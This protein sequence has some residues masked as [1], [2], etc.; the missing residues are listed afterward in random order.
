MHLCSSDYWQLVSWLPF[1]REKGKSPCDIFGGQ[2]GARS[3]KSIN[4]Q[5]LQN[6]HKLQNCQNLQNYH[7]LQNCQNLQKCQNPSHAF[8]SQAQA[9]LI[10]HHTN[11]T[12]GK[13]FVQP[14][15][16]ASQR[17][18]SV[19]HSARGSS[20]FREGQEASP[21]FCY[22][23]QST[24]GPGALANLLQ[25]S[26]VSQGTGSLHLP[27]SQPRGLFCGQECSVLCLR[28]A[29][30]FVQG[31]LCVV[32]R[33]AQCPGR[34]PI[35]RGR[36]S[37]SGL[38]RPVQDWPGHPRCSPV[39]PGLFQGQAGPGGPRTVPAT[40]GSEEDQEAFSC[41]PGNCEVG[42]RALSP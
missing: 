14:W 18:G 8:S 1:N 4:H 5:K 16:G 7:K 25:L 2:C 20:Q 3:I 38:S 17:L 15:P 21:G 34:V 24:Q 29:L 35:F 32:F 40:P 39:F 6:Y 36:S 10:H 12:F 28:S 9:S 23:L 19:V 26:S 41:C 42:P 13:G 27:I 11:S 30:C 33:S 37:V 31:V 22:L